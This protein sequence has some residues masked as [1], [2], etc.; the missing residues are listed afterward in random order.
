MF[1]LTLILA[2]HCNAALGI[3]G[4]QYVE[5]I[6]KSP[7]ILFDPVGTLK[8]INDQFHIVI[9]M[10]VSPYKVYIENIHETF[11]LVRFQCRE[12]S[13]LDNIKYQNILQPL[14]SLFKDI[15]RD[16]DSISHIISNGISKRSAWFAGVGVVFKHIFGTMNEDDAKHYNEAI[17]TLYDND[18]IITNSVKKSI[19]VSQIAM[20]NMNQSLQE[21]NLNQAKLSDAID[22]MSIAVNNVS[23][24]IQLDNFKTNL[25][26]ILNILQSS[27][28]TLSFKVEDILN[29]I[30]FVKANILHPSVLTPNQLYREILTN[31]KVVPKYRDFPI[32]LDLSNIH[33]LLNIADLVC[34]Y[35]DN[36]LVFVVKIPLVNALDYNLYK[37]IPLPTSHIAEDANSFAMIIP[38]SEFIALSKDKS[39]F[40]FLKDT[41]LCK[42]VITMKTFLC[43]MTDIYIV[44]GSPSCEIELITKAVTKLPQTCQYRIVYG[45]LDIWHKLHNEKWVFVQSKPAKLSIECINNK[46]T[47]LI[48]SGT[49]VLTIPLDCIAYHKNSRFVSKLSTSINVPI[50]KPTFNILNDSCCT[51][52]RLKAVNL[53]SIKIQ[54]VNLENLKTLDLVSDQ[55]VKDLDS[56]ANPLKWNNHVT[57]PILSIVSFILCLCLPLAY[58]CKKHKYFYKLFKKSDDPIRESSNVDP[59]VQS[60]EPR[61]RIG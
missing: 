22:R 1:L 7:G 18:K 13:G 56:I 4:N 30:L 28:L 57:F 29:S 61:L 58:I 15:L 49:G 35:L 41:S 3:D 50:V 33:V 37:S 17:K 20:S 40:T 8:L 21:M 44:A 53:P 9:P 38:S 6:T 60:I 10:D 32:S 39:S 11:N 59:E 12:N 5:P 47:E 16:F 52:D 46:I 51:L 14:D 54:N 24:A 43:D 25:N 23:Q 19:I 34:Y 2:T 45:D 42:N 26:S 36:K 48:I 31:L 27:L 55:V